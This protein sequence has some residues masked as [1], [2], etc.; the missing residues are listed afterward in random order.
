[1]VRRGYAYLKFLDA[2]IQN[3]KSDC[4]T[5]TEKAIAYGNE[6]EHLRDYLCVEFLHAKGDAPIGL[7]GGKGEHG[8]TAGD[9]T[10]LL[11][12]GGLEL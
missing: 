1:M 9:L 12:L 5:A 4:C 11:V 8:L 3:A 10:S 6:V 2:L 7:G